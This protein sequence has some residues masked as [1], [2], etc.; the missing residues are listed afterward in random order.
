MPAPQIASAS[1]AALA[2]LSTFAQTPKTRWTSAA[3][4]KFRQHG[5]FG[6]FSTVPDMGSSGPGAQI[7]MP[8]SALHSSGWPARTP[9]IACS[10]AAKPSR[11]EPRAGMGTRIF[12]RIFPAGSTSPAATLVPPISTPNVKRGFVSA[13]TVRIS[14]SMP[15]RCCIC[16]SVTRLVSG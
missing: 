13:G 3:S 2:S 7:P 16:S 10:T 8:A 11:A 6:G 4:G 5:R 1:A 12:A 9:R 14:Y 15:K